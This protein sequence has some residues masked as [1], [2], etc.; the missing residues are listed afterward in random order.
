MW[1]CTQ[2]P[3]KKNVAPNLPSIPFDYSLPN[4][5]SN[6]ISNFFDDFDITEKSNYTNDIIT[7][8]RVLFYDKNLSANNVVACGSC[9]QQQFAFADNTPT[10]KGFTQISGNRNTIS[11]AN[12]R[13]NNKYFW[14][15]RGVHLEDIVLLPAANHI[16]MGFDHIEKLPNRLT[17]LNYYPSLFT[18]AFGTSEIT[19]NKIK[20]ALA[21]FLRSLISINSKAD[22][23]KLFENSG[24]FINLNIFTESE[25]RGFNVLK[26]AKC[27]SCHFQNVL[28]KGDLNNIGLDSISADIGFGIFNPTKPGVFTTPSLRNLAFTAPYMHD[29]RFATLRDVLDH[30]CCNIQPTTALSLQLIENGKKPIKFNFTEQDKQDAINFLSTM[31]DDSL[32][33]NPKFANPFK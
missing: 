33:T 4:Q 2:L 19:N 11:L 15:A 32:T 20:I 13:F 30:Y 18:N 28:G 1:T 16:E 6:Q 3:I 17:L 12:A 26:N 29:G 24:Q 14:D 23:A 5:F 10:S 9:H 7:L 27:A 8:G 31:N 25:K 21:S 22:K